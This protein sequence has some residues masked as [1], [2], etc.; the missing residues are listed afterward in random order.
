MTDL[1]AYQ[2]RWIALSGQAV[3]GVGHTADEA[4]RL[5]RRNRPK[6]QFTLQFVE[7]AGGE[8]LTLPPLL[9][10][11]RPFLTQQDRPVYLVGG[12]VRDA[13]LNRVS[14]D[15]D[16][17]VP[18]RA[19]KLSFQVA[20]ALGVPAYALDKER[21]TGRVM[22]ADEGTTLDFARFRG[23]DLAADLR[24]RD[25][26][27]NAM[28]LPATAVSKHSIIDPC[29]GTADLQAGLIRQ[30]HEKAIANDPVRAL[31]GLRLAFELDFALAAETREAIAQA[32]PLLNNVSIERVR[33]E[34]LKLLNTA[35]P[36]QAIDQLSRL[37]LL[38]VILPEVA[39]LAD[40]VQSPPH[41][42]PVGAHTQSVLRWLVQI[43]GLLLETEPAN[44]ALQQAK[45][46][47]ADYRQPLIDHLARRIDGGVNGRIL[48]RLGALFHDAGKKETQTV[49]DDG[50][51]RFLGHDKSGAALA[52]RRLRRLVMSNQA[53]TH[54]KLIVAGHMRPLFLANEGKMPSR[55]AIFRYFRDTK[56]AGLDICLLALADHLATHDGPGET[57]QWQHLLQVIAALLSHYFEQ[58][59]ETVAPTPLLTGGDLMQ[60]L[61][62]PPGPEIGRL[63]RLIQEAQAAGEVTTREEALAFA[64]ESRQ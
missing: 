12:A 29:S 11:I 18:H 38:P 52:A 4:L 45:A 15:L 58:Y 19:I 49:G 31:R 22:L 33:D 64:K 30:T 61:N 50:R 8:P 7:E 10:R 5:A 1:S 39:A 54:V 35:V 6:E 20:D 59:R 2:G 56:E 53:I 36:D 28:A 27:I 48:L 32:A 46:M 57:K 42:E 25:F 55:R 13:L 41:H 9:E 44:S 40:V 51:I 3:A 23:G 34:L 21:D 17:V 16:F 14:H 43:E 47:L 26:T 37:Q 62:C 63:L 24:D 60:A